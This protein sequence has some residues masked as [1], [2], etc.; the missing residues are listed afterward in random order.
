MATDV[1]YTYYGDY[2]T[3]YSNIKYLH[4]TSETNMTLYVNYASGKKDAVLCLLAC[5]YFLDI[6]VC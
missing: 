6:L 2:F 1:N 3:L 5:N 4:H